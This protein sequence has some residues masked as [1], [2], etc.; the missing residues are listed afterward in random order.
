M[1]QLNLNYLKGSVSFCGDLADS[2][3][4]VEG[5]IALLYHKNFTRQGTLKK[6]D[7]KNY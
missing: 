5:K 4:L 3:C 2:R 7:S 6:D 1:K